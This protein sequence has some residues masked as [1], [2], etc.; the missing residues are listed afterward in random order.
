M[1]VIS[2]VPQPLYPQGKNFWTP[3][4][5]RLGGSTA[6]LYV[7]EKRRSSCRCK[8]SNPRL[9]SKFNKGEYRNKLFVKTELKQGN[10]C[11]NKP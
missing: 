8:E 7:S 2:L 4:N 11:P 6:S 5:G 9:S 3:A 10:P 1:L